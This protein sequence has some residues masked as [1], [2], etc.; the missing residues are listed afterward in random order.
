M[1]A[2]KTLRFPI[3]PRTKWGGGRR[4]GA[5]KEEPAVFW[6]RLCLASSLCSPAPFISPSPKDQ[7]QLPSGLGRGG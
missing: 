4:L 7:F 6:L 5:P 3:I 2:F 1:L